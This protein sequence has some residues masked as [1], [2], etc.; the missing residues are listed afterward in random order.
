MFIVQRE[1]ARAKSLLLG[2]DPNGQILSSDSGFLSFFQNTLSPIRSNR[3]LIWLE[4]LAER[5]GLDR[6]AT[7][8]FL[9][10]LSIEAALGL[11]IAFLALNIAPLLVASIVIFVEILSLK[12]K[13]RKRAQ[14]F[15]RDYTAFLLSLSSAVKTGQ[16]PLVAICESGALFE[17]GCELRSEIRKFKLQLAQGTNETKAL[18]NFA[19]SIDHPDLA[20]FRT[21][22][23]L[24]RKE[25]SS[26]GQCL[27]RLAKV[28][29]QRQS[30]R[31]K[32]KSAIAMQKLSVNG[33]AAS[34]LMIIF[35]QYRANPEAVHATWEHP[36]GSKLLVL[37]MFL[38]V[39]GLG[40]M[41]SL[42]RGDAE[43]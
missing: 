9:L 33:I 10:R 39:F 6:R 18:K 21:A 36:L 5:G 4:A 22:M 12:L 2:S 32:M 16:D 8:K 13:G 29:R 14:L 23:V 34:A 11:S 43:S 19:S 42:A 40:W 41:R 25:G 38:L 30:F 7:D 27:Q 26:L 37:G 20:L 24:A 1:K 28:T 17:S 3:L 15:E 35:V 31:R